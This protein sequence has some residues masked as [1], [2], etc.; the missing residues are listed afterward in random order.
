MQ[1][2]FFA[3][4]KLIAASDVEDARMCVELLSN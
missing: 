4:L 1:I 3:Y 2:S